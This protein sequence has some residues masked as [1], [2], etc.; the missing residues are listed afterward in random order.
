M[1]DKYSAE[2][3]A[4]LHPICQKVFEDF[5]NECE[6]TFDITLRITQG[7][8]TIAEQDS[9]YAQG[10]T[11][12]GNIV[13]NAKGGSSF[14][15]YGL[16]IDLCQ[17]VDN[18]TVVEWK[19]DISK[20]SQIAKKYSLDWGGNWHTLKDYPHFQFTNGYIWQDLFAMYEAYKLDDKGYLLLT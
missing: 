5:I 4:L 13:T 14:H 6:N 16:A 10:R 8:R 19:F 17:M 2:R 3:I 1:R 9:I 12:T 18:D 11:T 20:L 15:N 7:L